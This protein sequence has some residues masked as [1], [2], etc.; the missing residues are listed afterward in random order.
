M[1]FDAELPVIAR[2]GSR[3]YFIYLWHIFFV[4]L[5]RDHAPLHALGPAIA[6]ITT[7]IVAAS[8][9]IIALIMIRQ[10]APPRLCHWLGA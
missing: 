6:S 10:V 5:L 4:M 2:L 7:Y 9:S 1:A 3:S 8:G